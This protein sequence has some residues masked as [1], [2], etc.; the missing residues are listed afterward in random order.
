MDWLMGR[1]EG[2]DGRPFLATLEWL[3]CP[4]NFDKVIEGFYL[5]RGVPTSGGVTDAEKKAL[6]AKY[7][8]EEGQR[9]DRAI[10]REIRALERARGVDGAPG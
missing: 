7:T 2:R 1:R 6:I 8:D 3:V 9:D 10:Y 4:G 5:P